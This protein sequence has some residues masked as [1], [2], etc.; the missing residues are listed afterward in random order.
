MATAAR[1]PA[2]TQAPSRSE[3][4][5]A[6]VR[7]TLTPLQEG[8]RPWPIIVA[9]V[10]AVLVGAGDLI[11]VLVGGRI[12]FG[13]TH[14]GVGGVVLFSLMMLV[15]A[16]GMWRLRYWAVLG[17]Q[18][19]LAVVVLVFSLLLIRASNVLGL[20]VGLVVVGGGGTLFYK[21]V[22]VLSRLQMPKYPGR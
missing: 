11:D 12:T 7:A 16:G 6:A 15:C 22:R 13:R 2:R 19:I 10:I 21:L 5:N 3:Q 20:L 17:F 9:S 18:T 4:R 8:E 14:A 1:P